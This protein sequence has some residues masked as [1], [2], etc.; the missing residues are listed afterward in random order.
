M[1]L[2]ALDTSDFETISTYYLQPYSRQPELDFSE[3]PPFE[4]PMVLVPPEIIDMD[5][6]PQEEISG[7]QTETEKKEEWPEFYI[8]MFDGAVSKSIRYV[9][10][11]DRLINNVT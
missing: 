1:I 4:L 10:A 5:H 7:A 11:I 9:T 2:K 3:V 8:K 6:L